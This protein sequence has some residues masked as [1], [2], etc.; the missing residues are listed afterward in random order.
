MKY[1]FT[2][3]TKENQ[4]EELKLVNTIIKEAFATDPKHLFEKY[5]YN[6]RDVH[7]GMYLFIIYADNGELAG[8]VSLNLMEGD[9][10]YLYNIYILRRYR[11]GIMKELMSVV[12]KKL[13]K[14]GFKTLLTLIRKDA[15]SQIKLA[16]KSGWALT[17]KNLG[18]KRN[19][20]LLEMRL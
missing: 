13:K 7:I 10:L 18:R 6:K 3:I 1:K 11:G 15:K 8:F 14:L 20:N 2:N 16:L 12:R 4:A 17:S 9:L 19:F 5:P